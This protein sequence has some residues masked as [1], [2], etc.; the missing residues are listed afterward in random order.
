[1]TSTI[2]RDVHISQIGLILRTNFAHRVQVRDLKED[3]Y[4]ITDWC[5]E[6]FG[7]KATTDAESNFDKN[8]IIPLMFDVDTDNRWAVYWPWFFFR[9]ITDATLF[10]LRWG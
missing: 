1:M 6:Q 5:E 10:K 3:T 2:I 4:E 8:A 7:P 9:D